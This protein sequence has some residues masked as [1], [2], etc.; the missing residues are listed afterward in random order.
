MG[1]DVHA[2]HVGELVPV[3]EHFRAGLDLEVKRVGGN[4]V[5]QS[6]VRVVG[7]GT[8]RQDGVRAVL[9][10]AER[11]AVAQPEIPASVQ[12]VHAQVGLDGQVVGDVDVQVG[13]VDQA[14]LVGIV[15]IVLVPAFQGVARET[16]IAHRQGAGGLA[17]LVH[18]GRAALAAHGDGA[19]EAGLE[20]AAGAGVKAHAQAAVAVRA[21]GHDAVLLAVKAGEVIG[22]EVAV[23][24][25][26]E[27]V[28]VPQGVPR[29]VHG[30][31]GE[32]DVGIHAHVQDLVI[33]LSGRDDDHAVRASGAVE[34]R[35]RDVL[36]DFDAFD[37]I[38]VQEG[39][40][41][42]RGGIDPA[43]NVP[44]GVHVQTLRTVEHHTVHDPERLAVV[45]QGVETSDVGVQ[46]PCGTAVR[47]GHKHAR[48]APLQEG[49]RGVGLRLVQTEAVRDG[50][51]AEGRGAYAQQAQDG[52]ELFGHSVS[53]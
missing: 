16:G 27:G 24:G 48:D 10:Q 19:V 21:A 11:R 44:E 20:H 38:G 6:D 5:V 45:A 50:S 14:V 17:G 53:G 34:G 37:V 41:V 32:R 8:V 46:R 9:L 49:G 1:E 33:R 12:V 29:A 28:V 18:A 39:Q 25:N 52:K 7:E 4:G 43:G 26:A 31:I 22:R 2:V 35:G 51:L 47:C 36:D 13:G 42:E 23:G 40:V 3:A 15:H 30:G